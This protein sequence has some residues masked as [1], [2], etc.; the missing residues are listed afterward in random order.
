M[1]ADSVAGVVYTNHYFDGEVCTSSEMTQA[2]VETQD[3]DQES[4]L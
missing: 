3:V 1:G 2:H 4:I